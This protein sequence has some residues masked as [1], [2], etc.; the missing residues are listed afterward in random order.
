VRIAEHVEKQGDALYQH[1]TQLDLEGAVAKH[2]S[3]HLRGRAL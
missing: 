3:F 1:A 2:T